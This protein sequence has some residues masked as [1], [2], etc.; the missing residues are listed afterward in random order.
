MMKLNKAILA[1]LTVLIL[2]C[3]CKARKVLNTK[4]DSTAVTN[5]TKTVASVE[6]KVDT[7]KKVTEKTVVNK[8]SST[9]T[10][11]ATPAP[12]TKATIHKDGTITGEFTNIK[13]T[14]K[15][16]VDTK[17]TQKVTENSGK[18]ETKKVDSA[19]NTKQETRVIKKVKQVDAKPKPG[20][21]P[22]VI[23]ITI[24]IILI[25]VLWWLFGKPKG[26]K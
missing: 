9:T 5:T 21:W 2:F 25:I 24:G 23:P 20:I 15:K 14:T 18:S 19:I 13:S 17:E 12:G 7:S 16:K 4:T 26:S 3:G 1:V 8:D 22:L 6:T 10:I 11:E